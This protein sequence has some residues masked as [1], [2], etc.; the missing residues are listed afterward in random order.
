MKKDKVKDI[1]AS[2]LV[3]Q[4]SDDL[5]RYAYSKTKNK[6]ISED[7]VQDTFIVVVT[8]L[9]DFRGE[10]THKTWMISIL[11]NKIS[12]YYRKKSKNNI[13]DKELDDQTLSFTANG[14]WNNG[15]LPFLIK[16]SEHLLDNP[17]FVSVFSNCIEALPPLWSS[18]IKMKYIDPI[19]SK[20]ICKELK[21][22]D[23]NLWQIVHRSKLKLAGCLDTNWIKKGY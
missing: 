10:S 15:S 20:E 7:L 21:I 13:S 11:K 8:K 5:Y 18:V 9:D 23:T 14:R 17:D 1:T 4:F 16:D 22:S 12:D 2:D 6:V 3:N 19:K